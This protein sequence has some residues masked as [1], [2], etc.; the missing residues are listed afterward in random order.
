M[1]TIYKPLDNIDAAVR[2]DLRMLKDDLEAA[3]Y[4]NTSVAMRFKDGKQERMLYL[5]EGE[6]LEGK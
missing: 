5:L 3:G 6:W 2:C 1:S 4:E